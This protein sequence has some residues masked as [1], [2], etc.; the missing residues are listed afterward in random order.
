MSE[1]N[2]TE[3]EAVV[4]LSKPVVGMHRGELMAVSNHMKL[5]DGEQYAETRYRPRGRFVTTEFE[6]FKSFIDSNGDTIA[7]PVFIDQNNVSATGVLNFGEN[8]GEQGHCDY[9]ATLKLEPTVAWSKLTQIAATQNRF[10]QR[11]FATF[12][13]DWA[14]LLVAKTESGELITARDAIHA[15]RNMKVDATATAA[16][17]VNNTGES[18]SVLERV[19]TKSQNEKTPAYFE[20]VDSCYV[21]LDERPITLRLI[22]GTHDSKPNFAIQIV[23]AELIKDAIT[24]EFK[25]K[26]IDL[27]PSHAVRIGTFSA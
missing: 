19:E 8:D 14:D 27:I 13:E 11:D 4:E 25:Q 9:T 17:T 2:K 7:V 16:S 15:V 6:S 20:I 12:L 1:V 23:K 24:K 18:R 3:A 22:I 26:V 10:S 5:V 21:G